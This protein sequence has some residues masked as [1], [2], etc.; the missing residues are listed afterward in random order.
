M[1]KQFILSELAAGIQESATI[2]LNQQAARLRA[3]GK[4]MIHLGIGEPTNRAPQTAIEAAEKLLA[5]GSLKYT[6]TAGVPSLRQAIAD[7]MLASYGR[8]VPPANVIASNGSKH[9]LLTVLL[10]TV[11]PGEQVIIPAPYWV[12]YPEQVKLVRGRPIIVLPEPGS[13]LPSAESLLAAVGP[14]TRAILLNSPNNPSGLVLPESELATVVEFCEA[15]GIYLILDDIY[16]ELVFD[17]LRLPSPYAFTR[18]ELDESHV[19]VVN[20][21][22][23]LYGMT[24]LRLGWTVGPRALVEAMDKLQSQMTSNP[25]IL[26]Q[27]AA[28]GALRG[29]QRVV[30]EL[31]ATVEANRDAMLEALGGIGGLRI[32]RPQGGLFCFPDFSPHGSSSKELAERLLERALVVTVPGVEFGMDGHLRL[33]FAG[34]REEILEGVRRIRWALDPASPNEIR[35]GDRV[36][37]RDW[38]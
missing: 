4:P 19:I 1:T 11:N 31:R 20:G 25:S 38:A 35:L 22:S 18:F 21:V 27:A 36:A 37:V 23:K 12:T 6:A 26:S 10:A 9:S 29:D 14:L 16:R 30:Q 13:L 5:A 17:G 33:S 28:E 32:E 2:R 15:R 8:E 7:F 3:E 34:D 24:G